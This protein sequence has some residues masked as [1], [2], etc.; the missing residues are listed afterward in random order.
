MLKYPVHS[1]A[2]PYLYVSCKFA[3]IYGIFLNPVNYGISMGCM[4]KMGEGAIIHGLGGA[5]LHFT[6]DL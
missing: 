2:R 3:K 5:N 4:H 1:L 6:P